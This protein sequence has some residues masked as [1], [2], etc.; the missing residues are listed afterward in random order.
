LSLKETHTERGWRAA[1]RAGITAISARLSMF[2]I[3]IVGLGGTGSYV[4]DLVAKSAVR[5]I[6]LF[7]CVHS[8]TS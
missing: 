7:D 8:L 4:L 5:E 3:A 2:R 1:S 6:H